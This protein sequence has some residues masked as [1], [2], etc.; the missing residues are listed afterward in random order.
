MSSVPQPRPHS[1]TTAITSSSKLSTI[2]GNIRL[3]T[4]IGSTNVGTIALVVT[5]TK[6]SSPSMTTTTA[7][8]AAV[9]TL[10]VASPITQLKIVHA[11]PNR[12]AGPN[13][14]CGSSGKVGNNNYTSS[15]NNNH[16]KDQVQS[17]ISP[18]D[19]VNK[20]KCSPIVVCSRSNI[21]QGNF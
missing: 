10:T 7:T 14:S 4:V 1:T 6:S 11:E 2:D 3:P 8:T 17:T 5:S 19:V 15:N 16:Q 12:T 21:A 18:K 20:D 13:V 9:S